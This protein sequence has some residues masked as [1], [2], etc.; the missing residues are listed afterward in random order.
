[1]KRVT[2]SSSGRYKTSTSE[3]R[4]MTSSSSKVKRKRD[5]S[6]LPVPNVN[7]S[8]N[9]IPS[10]N[11]KVKNFSPFKHYSFDLKSDLIGKGGFGKVYKAVHRSSSNTFAVK[12]SDIRLINSIHAEIVLC[13]KLRGCEHIVYF[14]EAFEYKNHVYVFMELMKLG[15]LTKFIT[16]LP[17]GVS[18]KE[19]AVLFVVRSIVK[20]LVY[21]HE[22]QIIHRDI[23]SDNI[24]MGEDGSV[25]IGDFGFAIE[26]NAKTQHSRKSRIGTPFWMA[27]EVLS[28]KSYDCKVDVWSAGITI[29]EIINGVPPHH[30]L[31]PLRAMF[32]IRVS[33][34]P[35]LVKPEQW[36]DEFRDLLGKALIKNPN[37]RAAAHQV[38][39]HDALLSR[40]VAK[41]PDF[42]EMLNKILLLKQQDVRD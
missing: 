15:S 25:K 29:L 20:G 18:W 38:L 23:K 7:V 24:L 16:S 36:S 10:D 6:F 5:R 8:S 42:I 40:N 11:T 41:K 34:A 22:K 12:I 35:K 21:L 2:N 27:P 33:Q 26:L 1:M 13:H 31:K 3:P 14:V 32:V 4:T 17:K 30:E 37:E 39:S 9:R 19:S 28:N